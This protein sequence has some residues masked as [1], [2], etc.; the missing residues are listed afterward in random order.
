[1]LEL[2][3]QNPELVDKMLLLAANPCFVVRDDWQNA[4]EESVFD[5]F[6]ENL[7]NNIEKTLQRFLS[8]QVQGMA[9]SRDVLRTLR[10]AIIKQG[11]PSAKAL[12]AG[13]QI[14]KE[15]DLRP[16]LSLLSQPQ[17]W[18]LGE[19]DSLVP[20][21]LNEFLSIQDDVKSHIIRGSAH[22]PFVS[23]TE[24]VMQQLLDLIPIETTNE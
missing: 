12:E 4:V 23:H 20:V 17:H 13:L 15:S 2:A 3:K 24:E 8:L 19:R 9:E 16:R 5:L 22:L 10:A 7:Q 6:A 1:M 18:I 14:L 21:G 11:L